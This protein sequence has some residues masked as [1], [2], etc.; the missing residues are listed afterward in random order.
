MQ[1]INL[2]KARKSRR[3]REEEK[4]VVGERGLVITSIHCCVQMREYATLFTFLTY[5][6]RILRIRDIEN[7]MNITTIRPFDILLLRI[8]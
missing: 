2:I 4:V 3:R 6:E 7:I 5:L 1:L 8:K